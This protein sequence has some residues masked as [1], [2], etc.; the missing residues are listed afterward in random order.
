[1]SESNAP[2]ESDDIFALQAK[3]TKQQSLVK[4]LK[5]DGA[6]NALITE[7]VAVLQAL[8]ARLAALESKAEPEVKLNR[9]AFDELILRKMYVVPSFEIHNGPAG[10]FDY[11]PIACVLK[12]N[13]LSLWRQ[14]FTQE[15]NMLELECT[16]LTPSSVLETSGHVERFT[17]FMV[18]DEVTGECFR[19]DKLLEETVDRFLDAPA[20]KGLSPAEIEEHRLIQVSLLNQLIHLISDSFYVFS[21]HAAHGGFLQ[22]TTAPGAICS[23]QHQ[24]SFKRNELFDRSV[25]VQPDVQDNHRS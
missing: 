19:A 15:E 4:Q 7:G 22:R 9:K 6:Q 25:P 1:M 24:V 2:T 23:V 13:I 18:K 17:D 8:R 11:G 20:N 16:N 5:K 3:I 10:L 21:P 14:H 12:A